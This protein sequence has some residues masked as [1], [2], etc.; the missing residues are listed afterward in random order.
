VYFWRCDRCG[1]NL[2]ERERMPYRPHY[3]GSSPSRPVA[4]RPAVND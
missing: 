2:G 4:D 3:E 1:A